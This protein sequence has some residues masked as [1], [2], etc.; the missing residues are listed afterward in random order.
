[1]TQ[2]NY[3][4]L[5]GIKRLFTISYSLY[6]SFSSHDLWRYLVPKKVS[7]LHFD[8]LD[9]LIRFFNLIVNNEQV[10]AE[11]FIRKYKIF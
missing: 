3:K 4:K 10:R 6:F 11:L 9:F 1:M 5:N 7:H 2:T 8:P